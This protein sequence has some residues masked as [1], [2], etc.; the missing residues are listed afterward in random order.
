MNESDAEVKLWGRDFCYFEIFN[1]M[2][3][4]KGIIHLFQHFSAWSLKLLICTI[5]N[6]NIIDKMI[7]K[8]LFELYQ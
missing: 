4:F 8:I 2:I 6:D 3:L 5:I 1:P 7:E